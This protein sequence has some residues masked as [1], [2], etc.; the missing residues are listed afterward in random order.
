MNSDRTRKKPD[1]LIAA[2]GIE[3]ERYR[4]FMEDVAD[5][6]YE[7]NI[8]G[9]FEFSNDAFCRI[10]GYTCTEMHRRNYRE[11]MTPANADIAFENFNKVFRTGEGFTNILWEITTREGETR[12][13]QISASLITDA[14]GK[15]MGFRGIARDVTT[16]TQAA[17]SNQA[18]FRIAKALPR[19]LQVN[20]LLEFIIKETQDL[21][22]VAGASVILIDEDKKEFYFPVA[23]FED[24]ETDKRIKEVRFPVDKGVAGHVYRTGQPI[25][26]PDYYKS[27]YFLQLVDDHTDYQTHNMLDVPIR[28]QDRMIGVL[29]AVNKK[30]RD[31]DQADVFLMTTI[32]STVALP[33]EN[34]RINEELKR[35]YENVQSLNRAKDRVIHHLSHELKTPVS[36]LAASLGLLKKKLG[37]DRES[38]WARILSRMQRSLDRILEMQ[39][40]IED[41]LL[42]R[43]YHSYHIL[44]NL[45][46]L[47]ADELEVLIA[48]HLGD[49]DVLAA[50]RRQIDTYFGPRDVVSETIDLKTFLETL[51][52]ELRPRFAHRRC[53]LKTCVRA[54]EPIFI[55]AEV[56]RKIIT[57]LI[58]NAVENTPE[59][60]RI[61]VTVGPGEH[62]PELIVAD[63]GVGITADN[64]RLIFESN[65]SAKETIHY[66]SGRPFDFNAGGRGFDLLR[67]KIFSERYNFDIQVNSTRCRHIPRD[68]DLCPGDIVNCPHCPGDED[69]FQS[70]GTTMTVRFPPASAGAGK[71]ALSAK[72]RRA[73]PK[74]I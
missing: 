17:R 63:G 67:M 9:D 14:Q 25:I 36:V 49:E 54:V 16:E 68:M 73:W 55:P 40:E 20:Q 31:F 29:C 43:D 66:A 62:G 44:S 34:A 6:Y 22:G 1:P 56:L 10:F 38:S 7:T 37:P 26:V 33:I 11:F 3:G 65:F 39:Y 35:S 24:A 13:M 42:E 64:L 18:L 19:Y 61:T 52:G 53:E 2:R 46:D 28:L 59:G 15:K 27:P 70:G 4:V 32:A 47:C 60:G 74:A 12:L 8:G 50:I 69:C 57:G 58:R 5:G 23:T 48:D 51:V 71:N 30:G 21:I 41:I 45:L 72:S